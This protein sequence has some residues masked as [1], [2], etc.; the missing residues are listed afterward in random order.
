MAQPENQ[1]VPFNVKHSC[2]IRVAVVVFIVGVLA[3]SSPS[4]NWKHLM[5]FQSRARQSEAKV[6]LTAIGVAQ[7]AYFDQHQTY[8]GGSDCFELLGWAPE[9]ENVYAYYCG[10]DLIARKRRDTGCAP[11]ETV[12]IAKEAFTVYA[13]GNVDKDSTC[14]L[15]TMDQT[16]QLQNVLDDVQ[17]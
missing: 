10:Q 2:L 16:R 3:L 17:E 15:W 14:D 12:A 1:D 4:C 9:G 5:R 13:V 11:P 7:A 8:A 6:N